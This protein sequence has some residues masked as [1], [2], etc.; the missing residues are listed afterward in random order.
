[1]DIDKIVSEVSKRLEQT[2]VNWDGLGS[3]K[4]TKECIEKSL[5]IV[6]NLLESDCVPSSI[7]P[8]FSGGSTIIFKSRSGR[9]LV[10]EIGK[11]AS[12]SVLL[13]EGSNVVLDELTDDREG[14]LSD[15]VRS[16]IFTN[17]RS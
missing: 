10:I 3:P 11:D 6:R 16:Y 4:P 2:D 5:K 7:G 15:L 1:M 14:E 17:E 12:V 8:S 9:E 13:V